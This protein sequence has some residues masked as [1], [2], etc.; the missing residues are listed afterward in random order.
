MQH[1]NLSINAIVMSF[2]FSCLVF[3]FMAIGVAAAAQIDTKSGTWVNKDYKIKGEW[4]LHKRGDQYVIAF[5]EKFKTKNGPDLKVFLSPQTID[6][7]NGGNATKDATLVAELKKNKGSQEYV[8]PENF[9]V[10]DFK[11]LLIHCEA[12]SVLWGGTNL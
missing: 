12:Y 4:S 6:T 7:A 9:D 10:S 11:S 5:N 1:K 8:L 3:G 2:M